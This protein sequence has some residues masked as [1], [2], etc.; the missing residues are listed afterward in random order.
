V[1]QQ[2]A[3]EPAAS[4]HAAAAS[5]LLQAQKREQK[6]GQATRVSCPGRKKREKWVSLFNFDKGWFSFQKIL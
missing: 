6:Q 5:T 4:K 1:Q 2:L 3:V